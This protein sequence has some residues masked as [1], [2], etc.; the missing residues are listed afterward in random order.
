M[1]W[2]YRPLRRTPQPP[3]PG[4]VVPGLPGDPAFGLGVPGLIPGVPGLGPGDQGFGH[5]GGVSL[6]RH[7]GGRHG[8]HRGEDHGHHRG[9]DCHARSGHRWGCRF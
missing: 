8:H 9:E 2:F 7:E 1:C 5:H 6:G 4:W 3:M